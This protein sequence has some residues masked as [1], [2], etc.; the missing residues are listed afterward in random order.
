MT[1]ALLILALAMC[2]LL[3]GCGSGSRNASQSVDGAAPPVAEPTRDQVPTSPTH[4][5][6]LEPE[7]DTPLVEFPHG[8]PPSNLE[9]PCQPVYPRDALRRGIGGRVAVAIYVGTDGVV[10]DARA[11]SGPQVL[12]PSSVE[13]ARC[14]RFGRIAKDGRPAKVKSEM[15]FWYWPDTGKARRVS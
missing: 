12:Y 15:V 3:C 9:R 1:K 11:V 14:W 7:L 5:P 2:A 4:D 6:E 10:T 13:A 8:I